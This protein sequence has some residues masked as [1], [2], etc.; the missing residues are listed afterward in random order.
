MKKQAYFEELLKHLPQISS[1]DREQIY[2]Y[3]DELICDGVEAGKTEEEML[4]QFGDPSAL[5]GRLL[6]EWELKSLPSASAE[7]LSEIRHPAEKDGRLCCS[8]LPDAKRLPYAE[9]KIEYCHVK[10][11]PGSGRLLQITYPEALSDYAEYAETANGIFFTIRKR[12]IPFSL[13]GFR[14]YT[15]L[16]EIPK[17]FLEN[18][19]VSA[20]CG[21]VTLTDQVIETVRLASSNGRISV[22]NLAGKQL[23]LA[24]SN[25][26]V[27]LQNSAAVNISAKTSNAGIQIS[28]TIS[29]TLHASSSNGSL[30]LFNVKSEVQTLTTSNAGIQSKYSQ[31]NRCVY[32]TSNASI[33]VQ[34]LNA[35]DISLKTSNSSIL[36]ELLGAEEEYSVVCK[37]SNASCSPPSCQRPGAS[38]TLCAH[39]SNGS[40]G[41]SFVS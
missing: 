41:L 40:I 23:E 1:E 22:S 5:A 30:A 35:N 36:G 33:H 25:A 20:R 32:T 10:I 15:V 9:I 31:C 2:A 24:A 3:Y 38:R 11:V 26:A 4:A 8:F 12:R 34:S 21:S 14:S 6:D 13:F 37:T 39:T 27:T 19:N 18:L 17:G 29:Q 28:D 7:S 16:V